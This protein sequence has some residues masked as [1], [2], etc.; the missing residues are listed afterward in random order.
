M[1][2]V[3]SFNEKKKE[4]NQC[5]HRN[6]LIDEELWLIEC[7]ECHEKLDPIK[8]L[9]KLAREENQIQYKINELNKKAETIKNRLRTKCQHCGRMT[10]I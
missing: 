7:S 8:Y 2:N 5:K 4:F 10:N 6:I 3:V 1:G 9:L